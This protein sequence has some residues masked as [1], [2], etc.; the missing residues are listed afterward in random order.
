MQFT[1]RAKFQIYCRQPTTFPPVEKGH[2]GYYSI[3]FLITRGQSNG[4]L[5]IGAYATLYMRFYVCCRPI[6]NP[7]VHV[8]ETRPYFRSMI[9]IRLLYNILKARDLSWKATTKTQRLLNTFITC[10]HGTLKNR[11]RQY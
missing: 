1:R 3:P 6:R 10:P 8:T 9:D 11:N 7:W 2:T 4:H 5:I